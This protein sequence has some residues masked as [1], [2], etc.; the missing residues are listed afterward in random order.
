M[1]KNTKKNFSSETDDGKVNGALSSDSF[2]IYSKLTRSRPR[3]DF[4]VLALYVIVSLLLAISVVIFASAIK[5]AYFS[6][7]KETEDTIDKINT[8]KTNYQNNDSIKVEPITNELS[9]LFDIPV[10]VKIVEIDINNPIFRGLKSNDIIISVSGKKVFNIEQIE[11]AV[12][13]LSEEVFIT[14]TVYRNGVYKEINPFEY[15]E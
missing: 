8:I 4:R 10:G 12:S 14:Y 9:I 13:E 6:P 15:Q 7:P 1:D 5:T 11:L 3:F 2:N